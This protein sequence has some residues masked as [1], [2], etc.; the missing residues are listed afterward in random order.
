MGILY[1]SVKA[2]QEMKQ[3]NVI[4]RLEGLG[5]RQNRDGVDIYELQYRELV[6]LLALQEFR[7]INAESDS[8]KWF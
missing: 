1:N 2:H 7:D 8:N 3:K 6:M 4:D 5:V